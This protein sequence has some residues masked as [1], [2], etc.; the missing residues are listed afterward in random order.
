MGEYTLFLVTYSIKSILLR[1][2]MYYCNRE[3][4]AAH[5]QKRVVERRQGGGVWECGR[6][7][8]REIGKTS[9]VN[10]MLVKI[11]FKILSVWEVIISGG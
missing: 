2:A 3:E 8:R 6:S 9:A 11:P 7:W 4:E 5:C 10:R 1:N